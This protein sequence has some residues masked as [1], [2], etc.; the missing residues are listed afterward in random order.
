MAAQRV[1]LPQ[2]SKRRGF[3]RKR[4]SRQESSD[5]ICDFRLSGGFHFSNSSLSPP[6]L[7][8][9]SL[10]SGIGREDWRYGQT[11]SDKVK[12]EHPD[13]PEAV[14][15]R[16]SCRLSMASFPPSLSQYSVGR[17]DRI[18]IGAAMQMAFRT[19]C[20]VLRTLKCQTSK[21]PQ[22]HGATEQARR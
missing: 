16:V 4:Q 2:P 17:V 9:H 10:P 6:F 12:N 5:R 21:P 20:A 11:Q 7:C 18:D 19:L 15:R 1:V 14:S 8:G 22:G 13:L 3:A